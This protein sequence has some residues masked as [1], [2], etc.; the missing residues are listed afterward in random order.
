M[1]AAPFVDH[2]LR[3]A[4]LWAIWLIV[5]LFHVE[6]GLMPLFHGVSVEIKTHVSARKLPRIFLAML[7]YFLLPVLALLLVVHAI[8]SPGS[9]S[10]SGPAKAGQFWFS[11]AYSVTNV[12]HW[13]ADIRIPDSRADQVILMAVLTVTGL[14]INIEAWGWWR[15]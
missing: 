11:L 5:M 4:A 15:G 9:W 1:G 3:L 13:I 2:G 8:S 14:L 7:V 12:M 6:L 10:D